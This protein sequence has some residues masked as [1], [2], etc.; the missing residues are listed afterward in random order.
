MRKEPR[1]RKSIKGRTERAFT[2]GG[3]LRRFAVSAKGL[4]HWLLFAFPLLIP[5]LTYFITKPLL[6]APSVD[7]DTSAFRLGGLMVGLLLFEIIIGGIGGFLRRRNRD[8]TILQ[9]RLSRI[10]LA[11]LK[12]SALNPK[13]ESPT[14]H[15]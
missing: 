12:K 8:V 4:S 7:F 2:V 14:S 15:D 10:Y 6:K 1:I 9:G 5:F 11:A 13:L 3:I